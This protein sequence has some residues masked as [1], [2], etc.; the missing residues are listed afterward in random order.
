MVNDIVNIVEFYSEFDMLVIIIIYFI[1]HIFGVLGSARVK[2]RL[3]LE[4][5]GLL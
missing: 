3:G 1:F 2:G 5:K 4:T